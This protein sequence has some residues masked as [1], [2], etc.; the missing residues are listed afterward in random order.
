MKVLFIGGTGNISTAIS[1]QLVDEGHELYLLNRGNRSKNVPSG[2]HVLIGDIHDEIAIAKLIENQ[3]YDVV[4]DFIAFTPEDVERDFRLFNGKTSQYIVLSSASAYQKPVANPF[5]NE[6]TPLS[7]PYWQYSRD[8]AAS[9]VVLNAHYQNDGFPI[10]IV[11]PSHTYGDE[12]IPLGIHGKN[13]PWQ[14]LKRIQEGKPV[15]IPGDGTTYW[16]VT[17]NADFARAY[18]GLMGNP[19]AIGQAVQIMGEERLTWNQ[20][21]EIIAAKLGV[22]LNP[23]HVPTDLLIKVEEK[24]GYNF[25]GELL[26]DKANTALFDTSKLKALVPGF[27]GTV[28][29]D[30]ALDKIIPHFL[31]SPELQREDPDFDAFTDRVVA[32]LEAAEKLL[33]A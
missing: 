32:A 4:A 15:L 23:V 19:H 8:K 3:T 31:S 18:I 24:Y 33:L 25:T 7:N 14:V 11:R 26:G 13:G 2:A 1:R 30:Q 22:K 20:I 16:T 5:A 6:S 9:E 27:V 12:A 21:H 10:T 28:R 29:L 17:Y